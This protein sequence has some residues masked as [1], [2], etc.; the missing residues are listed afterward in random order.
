MTHFRFPD[1]PLT[2]I[3]RDQLDELEGH[4]Y[5][6]TLKQ[7]GWR[8]L[9]RFD[10]RGV[11]SY[12]SRENKPLPVS[13]TMRASFEP[14]LHSQTLPAGGGLF[15]GEWNSRRPGARCEHLW[16]FD[17]LE[18]N[19][20]DIR[21]QP[22][23]VRWNALLGAVPRDTSRF[24]V[25]MV[26]DRFGEFYDK[27]ATNDDAQSLGAEGIVLKHRDSRHVGSVRQ[28]ALNPQWIKCKWRSGEDGS[29]PQ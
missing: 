29:T 26:T 11:I 13:A 4:G 10:D 12:T 15:D 3:R 25:P 5:M 21:N 24:V 22:T 7:D 19:G 14:W 16:L 8:C 23:M 6:A 9:V 17:L 2:E 18:W 27:H 1:K 20:R 28:C